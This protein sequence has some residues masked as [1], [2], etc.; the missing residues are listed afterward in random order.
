M[1]VMASFLFEENAVGHTRAQVDIL[2]S[3]ERGFIDQTKEIAAALPA[4][5]QKVLASATVPQQEMDAIQELFPGVRLISGPNLH[6]PSR[7]IKQHVIDCSPSDESDKEQET[8]NKLA[9]LERDIA[10][11]NSPKVAVFCN[12]IEHCRMVENRLK[13]SDK[14]EKIRLVRPLHAAIRADLRAEHLDIVQRGDSS[15]QI[16]LVATDRASR[17]LDLNSV[18]HIIMYDFPEH[19]TEFL[20]RAGRTARGADGA[21]GRMTALCS[22]PQVRIA[23]QAMVSSSQRSPLLGLPRAS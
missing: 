12:A 21:G 4:E 15:R 8:K 2:V 1:N 10:A 6:R 9:A 11:S 18:D 20:R 23:R 17:G 22:G 19:P 3:E 14:G 7:R 5:S 16:I 13:R